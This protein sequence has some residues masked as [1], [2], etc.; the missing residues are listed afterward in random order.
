MVEV[1]VW[2]GCKAVALVLYLFLSHPSVHSFPSTHRRDSLVQ[3]HALVN[4]TQPRPRRQPRALIIVVMHLQHSTSMIR[5]VF[6][7]LQRHHLI[8]SSKESKCATRRYLRMG[9]GKGKVWFEST[10]SCAN[11]IHSNLLTLAGAPSSFKEAG[12]VNKNL[13]LS[14]AAHVNLMWL[15]RITSKISKKRREKLVLLL[16][17]WMVTSKWLQSVSNQA[18]RHVVVVVLVY[19]CTRLEE[20]SGFCD[21]QKKGKEKLKINLLFVEVC[22]F[23][24]ETLLIPNGILPL[25]NFDLSRMSSCKANFPMTGPRG[26]QSLISRA[27]WMPKWFDCLL[28]WQC[29]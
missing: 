17:F 27:K 4:V 21:T 1:W 12:I 2:N 11:T 23:W 28:T 10:C 20:Y 7:C 19:P 25:A 26:N 3:T 9:G 5:S 13:P 16:L 8:I 14:R 15:G 29:S 22:T 18:K 24:C 6:H